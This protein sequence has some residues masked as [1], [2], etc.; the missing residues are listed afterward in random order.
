M[1]WLDVHDRHL[2]QQKAQELSVY[3]TAETLIESAMTYLMSI[4][5]GIERRLI[6][7]GELDD[8]QWTKVAGTK[9]Y[10]AQYAGRNIYFVGDSYYAGRHQ[11]PLNPRYIQDA[12]N[13]IEDM[14]GLKVRTV[15][16]D[17]LNQLDMK[18]YEGDSNTLTYLNVMN[19]IKTMTKHNKW[20]TVLLAQAKQEIETRDDPI[21]TDRD[22]EHSNAP[23]QIADFLVG[24]MRP[25]KYRDIKGCLAAGSEYHGIVIG[26]HNGKYNPKVHAYT[27]LFRLNKQKDG[28]APIDHWY[29]ADP[30]TARVIDPDPYHT[31]DLNP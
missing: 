27:Q 9:G 24:L 25:W 19:A 7:R 13:A 21:P 8:E 30:A 6:K 4:E 29:W 11:P 10:V 3:V 5:T 15:F 1:Q 20:Q 2:Q 16:I 26:N 12:I 31:I 18:G 23:R 14:R 22:I 17:Y 28:D